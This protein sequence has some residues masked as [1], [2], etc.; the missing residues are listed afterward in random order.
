MTYY[1]HAKQ[2]ELEVMHEWV[3]VVSEQPSAAGAVATF[4]NW[5]LPSLMGELPWNPPLKSALASA[6][7]LLMYD[8]AQNRS[9]NEFG[10]LQPQWKSALA[11]WVRTQYTLSCDAEMR[12]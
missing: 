11:R 2:L 8:N 5:S 12:I 3:S 10:H 7:A 4:R 9:K 6:D 1:T